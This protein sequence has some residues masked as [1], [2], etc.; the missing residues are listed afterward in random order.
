MRGS[1]VG[2]G[3]GAFVMPSCADRGDFYWERRDKP[4]AL[5]RVTCGAPLGRIGM[6]HAKDLE[7]FGGL[8]WA[9]KE[10]VRKSPVTGKQMEDR[11]DQVH[12][13]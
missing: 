10:A 11:C 13:E 4:S 8:A 12:R 7:H 6:Q 1:E 2:V 5:R 9:E 3:C